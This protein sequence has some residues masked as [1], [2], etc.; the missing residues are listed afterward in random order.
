MYYHKVPQVDLAD[1]RRYSCS[2]ILVKSIPSDEAFQ[3]PFWIVTAVPSLS[4]ATGRPNKA[5]HMLS[6]S[7]RQ[8]RHNFL[9]N[10]FVDKINSG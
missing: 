10:G 3:P 4:R 2:Q 1:F 7:F 6:E 9:F 5:L 8:D